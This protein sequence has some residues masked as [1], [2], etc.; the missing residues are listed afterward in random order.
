[1]IEYKVLNK[2]FNVVGNYKVIVWGICFEISQEEIYK[3]LPK[4]WNFFTNSMKEYWAMLKKIALEK[5]ELWQYQQ[6]MIAAVE[7]V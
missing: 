2:V 6:Q 7:S 4:N 5:Y 3:R 1:M